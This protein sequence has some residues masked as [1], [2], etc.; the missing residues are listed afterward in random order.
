GGSWGASGIV[1][2]GDGNSLIADMALTDKVSISFVMSGHIFGDKGYAFSGL[3]S[4]VAHVMSCEAPTGSGL[5]FLTKFGNGSNPWCWEAFTPTDSRYIFAEADARRITMTVDLAAGSVIYYLDNAVWATQ[6]DASGSFTDLTTFTVGRQLWAEYMCE[7]TDFRIYDEILAQEHVAEIVGDFPKLA[8]KPSPAHESTDNYLNVTLSWNPGTDAN[9][10]QVYFSTD[11]SAVADADTGSP[12]YA[13]EFDVNSYDPGGLELMKTYYWRVDEVDAEGGTMEGPVWQFDTINYVMVEDFESYDNE[14]NDVTAVWA[15][16]LGLGDMQRLLMNDPCISPVNSMRLRYQVPYPPYWAITNRSF[17]PAQDW[18][19]SGVKIL[20]INYYGDA[21]NFT[22]PL[23]VTIGDGTTD[24]NVVITD[25]NTLVEGWQEIN[26][27]LPEISAAGVDLNNVSYMEIGL[28]DGTNQLMSSSKWDVLYIDDIALYPSKCVLSESSL[29]ADITEDCVVSYD[30]LAY[31]TDGWLRDSSSAE[32]IAA[33]NPVGLWLFDDVNDLTKATIGNNLTTGIYGGTGGALAAVA[34]IAAG[35]GAVMVP[36]N[37]H[38]IVDP[39]IVPEPGETRVNEYTMVWDVSIPAASAYAPLRWV[40]LCE[41]DT[42]DL[43]SDVDISVIYTSDRIDG[44]FGTH[45]GWSPQLVKPDTWYQLAVSVKNGAFF[46][47]YIN[48]ELA[49]S[50]PAEAIDGRYSIADTFHI[51]KDNDS[52]DPDIN[53]STFALFDRALTAAEI[54][55]LVPVE[56]LEGDL[57]ADTAI[58]FADY[59]ILA[60]EWLVEDLWP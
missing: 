40:G 58:D 27:S 41:F 52:E 50:I 48:G 31:I 11:E 53:C 18:T 10:H 24:A 49:V 1:F 5:H 56:L 29:Q 26:V 55:S 28:G 46:N 6:I 8:K 12:V 3:D 22:L 44:S 2:D 20:T 39:T 9:S 34:G 4:A 7:M 23:F 35:D 16:K 37:T 19:V 33:A 60:G 36:L 32:T 14:G 47:C 45:Q 42:V 13:G 30:D 54:K 17:S 21:A 59:S 15:D 38:L 57:N 51:F 43:T 25:V